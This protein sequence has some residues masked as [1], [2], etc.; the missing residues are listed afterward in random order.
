MLSQVCSTSLWCCPQVLLETLSKTH[1]TGRSQTNFWT[2]KTEFSS[3]WKWVKLHRAKCIFL[4]KSKPIVRVFKLL[5]VPSVGSLLMVFFYFNKAVLSQ[6]SLR[7]TV[8]SP[9]TN[10]LL[11]ECV[12]LKLDRVLPFRERG[13]KEQTTQHMYMI[14]KYCNW[15]LVGGHFCEPCVGSRLTP[16]SLWL[17]N[18]RLWLPVHCSNSQLIEVIKGSKLEIWR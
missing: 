1:P 9:V 2:T 16:N 17:A 13:G 11:S 15:T 5:I 12:Q 8:R 10:K 6:S 3:T 18:S 14:E 4:V 7:V